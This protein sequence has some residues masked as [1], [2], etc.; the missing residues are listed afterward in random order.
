[1]PDAVPPRFDSVE[2]P[3]GDLDGIKSVAVAHAVE[4][5]FDSLGLVDPDPDIVSLLDWEG[6]NDV[7]MLAESERIDMGVVVVDRV[8]VTVTTALSVIVKLSDG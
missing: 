3:D 6:E 8:A 4:R 7:S 1:M 2:T 5:T